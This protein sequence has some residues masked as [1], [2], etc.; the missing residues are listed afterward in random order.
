MKHVFANLMYDAC[1]V[2]GIF[3]E[4]GKGRDIRARGSYWLH[5]E[6]FNQRY[7]E[8]A[9]AIDKERVFSEEKRRGFFYKYEMFYNQLMSCPVFSSLNKEQVSERYLQFALHSFVALDMYKTFRPDNK[10]GFYYHLHHFLLS[11]HCSIP[12]NN[13]RDIFS[14]VRDYLRDRIDE[15]EITNKRTLQPIRERIRGIKDSSNQK[16]S[17]ML[18]EIDEC[19]GYFKKNLK[20][21]D[22]DKIKAKLN[23]FK[24]AYI[25]LTIMLAFERKTGLVKNISRSYRYLQL[26]EGQTDNYYIALCNYIYESENFDEMLLG[27]LIDEFQKKTIAPFSV[28][29]GKEAWQDVH[30]IWDI[31]FNSHGG[32]IFTELDLVELMKNLKRTPDA[33]VLKPYFIFSKIL[34]N[35]CIDDL[36]EAEIL[37]DEISSHK[38][39]FGYLPA[40]CSM[41]K[42]ALKIKSKGKNIKN[43]ELTA[44]INIMLSCQSVF[45]DGVMRHTKS[46]RPKFLLTEYENNLQIMHVIKQY[47]DLVRRISV[48]NELDFYAVHPQSLSGVLDDIEHALGKIIKRISIIKENVCSEKLAEIFINEKILT[49]RELNKTLIS[50]LPEF[51]LYNFILNIDYI[52]PYLKIPGEMLVN[53]SSLR[54]LAEGSRHNRKIIADAIL[55]AIKLS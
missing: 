13:E 8:I 35:I 14:G 21:A 50:Y 1:Q 22:F 40:A 36:Q 2:F 6:F 46:E 54:A 17:W 3:R 11:E 25:S 34:Y 15:I 7:N 43:G 51:T 29:I 26:D 44:D 55:I 23:N 18:F 4:G 39:P 28:T 42:L 5:Q 37:L 31:V 9:E 16:K 27:T 45:T 30:V 38:L 47:N 49:T 41:L 32:E 33:E 12:G 53:I 52:I 48:Y 20:S 24:A 10:H 19:I